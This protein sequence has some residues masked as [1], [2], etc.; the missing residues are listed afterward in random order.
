VESTASSSGESDLRNLSNC[1]EIID[2]FIIFFERN[3]EVS[4]LPIVANFQTMKERLIAETF[5]ALD[6][7]TLGRKQTTGICL[8]TKNLGG[9]W[10]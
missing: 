4:P 3:D 7:I 10:K 6:A 5:I 1:F 8:K 9:R 2:E